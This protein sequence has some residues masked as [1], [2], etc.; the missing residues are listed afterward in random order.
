MYTQKCY[1]EYYSLCLQFATLCPSLLH[2]LTFAKSLASGATEQRR[3]TA[4]EEE[5][6]E[7]GEGTWATDRERS[8]RSTVGEKNTL[9]YMGLGL[10]CFAVEETRCCTIIT[11]HNH[12]FCF[13]LVFNLYDTFFRSHKIESVQ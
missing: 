9:L 13:N 12:L 11:S 2:S 4:E 10:F 5:P 7:E 1:T 6:G 8:T 3:R